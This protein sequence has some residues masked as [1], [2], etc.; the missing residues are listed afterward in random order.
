MRRFAPI[1]AAALIAAVTSLAAGTA[2][3]QSS[4]PG[5]VSGTTLST[6][7]AQTFGQSWN[8]PQDFSSMTGSQPRPIL[9]GRDA[10]LARRAARQAQFNRNF[11][12]T[13]IR[14][15]LLAAR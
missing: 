3:A 9:S 4:A 13:P 2:A 8:L 7:H 5:L 14:A 11:P 1:A 12:G 6:T 15:E 10:D